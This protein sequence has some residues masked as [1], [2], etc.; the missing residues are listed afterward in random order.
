M[1]WM[2]DDGDKHFEKSPEKGTSESRAA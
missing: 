1:K 2:T